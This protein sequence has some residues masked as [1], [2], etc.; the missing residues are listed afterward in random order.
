MSHHWIRTKHKPPITNPSLQGIKCFPYHEPFPFLYSQENNQ[1]LKPSYF[2]SF[3][4]K[5]DKIKR[6]ISGY[7]GTY[8]LTLS[9]GILRQE[10][11]EFKV[12]I[13]YKVYLIPPWPTWDLVLKPTK[14]K[15][16]FLNQLQQSYPSHI[17]YIH[18]AHMLFYH[19]QLNIMLKLMEAFIWFALS[20]SIC[21][22]KI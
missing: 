21:I 9:L 14:S 12:I 17:H 6:K 5:I 8:F 22:P 10:D 2:F 4:W 13:S 7:R 16:N 19:P 3:S 20:N 18:T 15:E 11:Q 1:P